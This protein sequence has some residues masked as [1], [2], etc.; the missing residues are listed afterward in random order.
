[1][2]EALG[3]VRERMASY[4]GDWLLCGGW[5]VDAWLGGVTRSHGDIDVVVFEDEQQ[6]AFEHLRDWDMVAH[7]ALDPTQERDPWDGRTLTLP[8]HVHARPRDQASPA[9]LLRWVTPPYKPLADDENVELIINE[10][11]D[12]RW[13]LDA[14]KGI[15]IAWQDAVAES[16]WGL[17][18]AVPEVLLFYKATD[19][20]AQG[21]EKPRPHDQQDFDALFPHLAPPARRWLEE[22]LERMGERR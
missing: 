2:N 17:P 3:F 15:D 1:M 16:P 6:L 19:Y 22:A 10:R 18:T 20:R 14:A 12:G 21:R 11:R 5:A 13:L 7:D 9:N 8:A 4:P